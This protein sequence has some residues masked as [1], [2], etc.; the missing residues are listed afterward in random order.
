MLVIGFLFSEKGNKLEGLRIFNHTYKETLLSKYNKINVE[1][2]GDTK[3]RVVFFKFQDSEFEF[4]KI[5]LEALETYFI[6][7]YKNKKY[8]SKKY[9]YSTWGIS[10]HFRTKKIKVSDIVKIHRRNSMIEGLLEE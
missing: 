7:L 9:W 2:N 8:D 4:N 3:H 1:S 5:N 6:N 10:D